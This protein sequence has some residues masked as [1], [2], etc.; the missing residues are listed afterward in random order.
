MSASALP[1]ADALARRQDWPTMLAGAGLACYL[2]VSK[3]ALFL[4]GIPYDTPGGVFAEKIH[5]GTYAVLLAF[6]VLAAQAPGGALRRAIAAAPGAA[7]AMALLLACMAYQLATGGA[8]HLIVYIES[9]LPAAA[10]ALVLARA[11]SPRPIGMLLLAALSLNAAM[12]LMEAVQQR[13]WIPVYLN[14]T[15]MPAPHGEFR[16][17]ALYDHPLTGAMLASIACF[18]CAGL[19]LS[20]G[21][22]AALLALNA[23]ALLAFGGRAALAATAATLLPLGAWHL[24][25]GL[26][27]RRIAAH[28]LLLGLLA[29][30]LGAALLVPL[31]AQSGLGERLAAKFYWDDSAAARGVQWQ[32]L[33]LLRPEEILFGASRAR[34]DLLVA[35]LGLRQPFVA[36]ENFWLI[37]FLDLGLFGFP[38]FLGAVAALLTSVWRRASPVARLM[39]LGVLLT[40]S[41]SNSLGRKS[42]VLTVLVAAAMALPR[43]VPA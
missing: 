14:D 12:A 11:P 30:L 35:N 43:R 15:A 13:Q 27:L 42:C 16:P 7:V 20:P 5:P 31:L 19:D 18:L 1:H 32:V 26:A 22:R 9:F 25:R 4:A 41:T 37:L 33:G 21:R 2:L 10:M 6:A 3:N 8:E 23:M 28:H 34:M 36:I 39:L 38:L 24:L 17:T 29:L 40:A